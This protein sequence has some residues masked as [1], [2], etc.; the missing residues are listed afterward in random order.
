MN[1]FCFIIQ[2]FLLMD[3]DNIVGPHVQSYLKAKALLKHAY[4]VS[5]ICL[6]NNLNYKGKI[7]QKEGLNIYYVARK[8]KPYRIEELFSLREI[9]KILDK[10]EPDFV[11]TR[12]RTSLPWISYKYC[13]RNKKISVWNAARDRDL[14]K[15]SYIRE[16]SN[17]SFF[18]YIISF[19]FYY[20]IMIFLF[21]KGIKKSNLI[22]VQNEF[23][24][25]SLE[26]IFNL[27]NTVLLPQLV[28]EKEN[29]IKKEDGFMNILWI[30][31]LK[32]EKAP[33]KYIEIVNKYSGNNIEFKMIGKILDVKY[34]Y[35]KELNKKNFC[36]YGPL[37]YRETL[38]LF[39]ES[40]ILI[41]TSLSEGFPNTFVQAWRNGMMVISLGVNP[42]NLLDGRLGFCCSTTEEII[43]KINFIKDNELI[44][45]N[46]DY[47]E[48]YIEK[49]HTEFNFINAINKLIKTENE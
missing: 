23:Q 29:F 13:R 21:E 47:I 3:G 25:E 31:S 34:N 19:P 38:D 48:E 9:L 14:L 8:T 11:Y 26:K 2:G 42:N 12:G 22:F 24:K 27:K 41:N 39:K 33:E 5:Y 30:G 35:I 28:S 45:K 1:H 36:Y 16:K 17:G 37:S 7:E 18:K 49:N 15:Y 6:T 32:E 4:K 40:H 46:M 20:I 10:I 44:E 43:D